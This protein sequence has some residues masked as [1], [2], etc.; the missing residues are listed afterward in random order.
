MN[1]DID[2]LLRLLGEIYTLCCNSRSRVPGSFD[3]YYYPCVFRLIRIKRQLFQAVQT[4]GMNSYL[5]KTISSI[6]ALNLPTMNAITEGF[7]AL[8]ESKPSIYEAYLGHFKAI[9]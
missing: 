3:E 9:A 2:F 5:L 1:A 7:L 6:D 4:Q 8:K